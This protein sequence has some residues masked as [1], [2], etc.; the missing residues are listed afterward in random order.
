MPRQA[1]AHGEQ[2]ADTRRAAAADGGRVTATG[3]NTSDPLTVRFELQV[4][5]GENGIPLS[6]DSLAFPAYLDA[7]PAQVVKPALS[8]LGLAHSLA[9]APAEMLNAE[10]PRVAETG[11]VSRAQGLAGDSNVST[12]MIYTTP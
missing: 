5:V 10:L 3:F 8:L 4:G 9:T 2:V 1:T 6:P 12:T 11:M 7:L